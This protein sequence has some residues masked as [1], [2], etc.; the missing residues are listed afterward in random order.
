MD[1]PIVV[2]KG[3]LPSIAAALLLVS[4]GGVRL[5]PLAVGLW[6]DPNGT[7]WLLWAVAA[8]SAVALFEHFGVLRARVAEAAAV[9]TAAL[10]SWLVLMKVA[11]RWSSGEVLLHIGVGGLCV[12][13]IVLLLRRL[14]QQAPAGLP[15][16]SLATVVLSADAALLL[17]AESALQAQLAGA[18]AAAVGAGAGTWLWRRPFALRAADA[19]WFGFAHGLFL[20]A[21]MHLGYLPWPAA[22]LAAAAPVLPLLL[23]KGLCQRPKAWIVFAA[24]VTALPFAA[25][26]WHVLQ[27]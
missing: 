22:L 27:R 3:V 12:T 13:A 17:A 25:A 26:F 21:G 11:A 20:L 24:I 4:L 8:A 1:D 23:G 10:G 9:L 5:L 16:A 18:V 19:T 14:W 15:A 6:S 2:L 7:E